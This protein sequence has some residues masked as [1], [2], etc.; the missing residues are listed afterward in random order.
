[1]KINLSY[2]ITGCQKLIDIDDEKLR[3]FYDKRM[4][5]EVAGENLGDE[6]K[7][8]VFRISGG[9]DKQGF[10][11][12]Q[13]VITPNRVRLLLGDGHS[14]F[15]IR[16]E[17]E[18]RRK[19]VRGCIVSADLAVLNLVVVRKGGQEI[20]GLTDTVKPRRRG[21]K[22]FTRIRK[23]FNL[24]KNA[25]VSEV[26]GLIK[27]KIEK[28]GKK[29]KFKQPK[30]QRLVTPQRLQHRRQ[31]YKEKQSR[32]DSSKKAAET[33]NTLISARQKDEQ[34][35]RASEVAKRRSASIKKSD[36]KVAPAAATAPKA[37]K[38]AKPAKTTTAATGTK[39]APKPNK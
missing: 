37:A 8:Y 4:S 23:L 30:I 21:P 20:A 10:P 25:L 29:P 24:N 31:W 9:N 16:R 11:M 35:K 28:V 18:R 22:R 13:G 32:I 26:K 34:A 15:R 7:N 19:S 2:P 33:Y 3:G 17:G 27:R 36:V 38:P 1:M 5:T 6:F 14:C 12:K 39:A